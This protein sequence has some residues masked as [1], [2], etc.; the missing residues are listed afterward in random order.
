M[1][2]E[3]SSAKH[4][5]SNP[6][7][8]SLAITIIPLASLAI[9][10]GVGNS[11][12]A[13]DIYRGVESYVESRQVHRAAAFATDCSEDRQVITVKA[14]DNQWE[15][16]QKYIEGADLAPTD[17]FGTTTREQHPGDGILE[18]GDKVI[19]PL[20]CERIPKPQN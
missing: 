2:A 8:R 13:K 9:A 7:R 6:R 17:T 12:K 10:A 14:G 3:P 16:E 4:N 1:E 20:E 18:P 11:S 5:K 15:L 19:L